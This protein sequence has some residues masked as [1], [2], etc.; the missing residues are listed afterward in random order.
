[1]RR[2]QPCEQMAL[3]EEASMNT[4]TIAHNPTAR[5]EFL[6]QGWVLLSGSDGRSILV[7]HADEMG[8]LVANLAAVTRKPDLVV[9]CYP[10]LVSARYGIETCG[11]WSEETG[12]LWRD[13]AI[14]YAPRSEFN[15]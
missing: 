1:M 8:R 14:V 4:Q 11:T 12:I 2:P 6:A 9:C 3:R 5:A 15:Q 7:T 10:G 13:G